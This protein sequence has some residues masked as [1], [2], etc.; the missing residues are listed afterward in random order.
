MSCPRACLCA[1]CNDE[2]SASYMP[3]RVCMNKPAA[4]RAAAGAQMLEKAQEAFEAAGGYDADKRIANVLTGLGF[5]CGMRQRLDQHL[6]TV[7]SAIHVNSTRARSRGRTL[8]AASVT[9]RLDS[10][11]SL[12]QQHHSLTFPPAPQA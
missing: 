10:Q 2:V 7:T 9:R 6:Y 11:H 4:L 8:H 1:E 3:C 12:F 5:R